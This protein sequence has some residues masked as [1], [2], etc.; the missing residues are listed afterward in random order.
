[1]EYKLTEIIDLPKHFDPRGSLTVAEE[2]K[3]IPFAFNKTNWRYGMPLDQSIEGHTSKTGNKFF[4]A[5]AGSFCITTTGT[6][7]IADSILLNHP[8]QGLWVKPGASYTIHD[9]SYGSVCL[10]ISSE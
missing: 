7:S 4:V 10:E 2:M 6:D 8:F 3:N 5:L 1:M 9:F